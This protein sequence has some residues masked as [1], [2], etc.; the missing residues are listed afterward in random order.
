MDDSG[1]IQKFMTDLEAKEAGFKTLLTENEAK[2]LSE[3]PTSER[4]AELAW[5]K[6]EDTLV[7]MDT[8]GRLQYK[9]GFLEGFKTAFIRSGESGAK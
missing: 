2:W 8:I 1:N 4:H 3:I 7:K 9:R 5:S 6:H